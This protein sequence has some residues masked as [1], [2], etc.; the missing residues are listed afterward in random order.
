MQ[1]VEYSIS[2]LMAFDAEIIGTWGCLP[3][4]YPQVLEMVL[5][6]KI[7]LTPFVQTRPMSTIAEAFDEAHRKSPDQRIILV[8]DF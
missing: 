5:S 2:R 1:K 6:G 7:D 8:P 3:E 4:Y